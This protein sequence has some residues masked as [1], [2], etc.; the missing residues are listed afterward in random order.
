MKIDRIDLYHLSMPLVHPFETS[1]GLETH[2]ECIIVSAH[3]DGIAGWGECAA[4]HRP[5]YSYETVGTAWHILRDFLIPAV[6]GHEWERMTDLVAATQWVRGH[7]MAKA[8]LQ[9]AA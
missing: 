6:L 8:A 5:G 9:A 7:R 1:F 2:R 3:A 4:M